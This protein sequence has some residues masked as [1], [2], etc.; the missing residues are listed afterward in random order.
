MAIIKLNQLFTEL[1]NKSKKRLVVAYANDAHTIEAVNK[2]VDM[3]IIEAS[4]VG[5]IETIIKA[6]KEENIESS[7][8]ELIQEA[9]PQKLQIK[10]VC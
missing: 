7:K 2:A 9:D 5:D 10:H 1:K 3:G 4:L 8:F 6:C